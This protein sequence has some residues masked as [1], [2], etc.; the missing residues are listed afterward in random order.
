MPAHVWRLAQAQQEP[1]RPFLQDRIRRLKYKMR[2][3]S[4]FGLPND[5][6]MTER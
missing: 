3:L 5:N 6:L 4:I 2:Q 1:E